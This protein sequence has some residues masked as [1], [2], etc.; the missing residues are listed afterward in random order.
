MT[1]RLGTL[2]AVVASSP[3]T[4]REVL[5]THNDSLTGRSPPDAWL[6]LGHAANSVFVLPPG[7]MWRALR[8]IGTEHLLSARQLDGTRLRPLLRDAV[9]DLVRRVSGMAAAG[10]PVEVGRAAFAAMMDLQWRAM[11]SA[12]LDD[13]AARTLHDAAREAVALSLKPNVSDFFPALAAADLQGLRRRFARRVAMVYQM[14]DEK[15]ERR[16]RG[17][18]EAGGGSSP[19]EKDL[20]DAMHDMSE[21]GKDDG[22]VRVNISHGTSPTTESTTPTCFWRR[23][24]QSRAQSSG[25]W[26]S[27][28][29]TPTSKLQEELRR[30][31]ESQALV[32]HPDVDRLPYLRAA[33]RETLRLHPVV[34]LVR[35]EAEE[36][37]QI[38]GRAVPKGCTVLVN[39]WAVHRDAAAWPEPDR[40]MPERFLLLR[41]EEAAFLGTTEFELIPFSAGRRFC[42][43]FPLATRM[44][45]AMLG[46][47]LH[48]FEWALP[49]EAISSTPLL[50]SCLSLAA[51]GDDGESV[52]ALQHG[53]REAVL[54]AVLLLV[55]LGALRDV[56]AP[57]LGEVLLGLSELHA[58]LQKLRLLLPDCARKGAQLWVLMNAKLM[59]SELRLALGSVTATMDV[60]GGCRRQGVCGR[61]GGRA[62]GI[63]P[64][65]ARHGTARPREQPRRV[66]RA[67]GAR[68]VPW[69]RHAQRRGRQNRAGPCGRR[70]LVGRRRRRSWRRSA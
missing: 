58:T 68:V 19:G 54:V 62:D 64:H 44:V 61:P 42:L 7:R 13:A 46:S 69:R 37:V 56:D 53:A 8:R 12:G 18:R 2:V 9:L 59:A 24:T 70:H 47:L 35:N 65:V 43:G 32:E 20:L 17:R 63:R 5:Q 22:V 1:V 34:P 45:H 29:S 40:F 25:Q 41:P 4:A 16:M 14:I 67:V 6:A 66:K 51:A 55:I 3:S 15:I 11:F 27:S 30:V 36:T 48:R 23:S 49:R 10:R 21:Q 26:Q 28:Y 57:V 50:A 60:L 52:P 38:Q 31:L 39:L 33:I